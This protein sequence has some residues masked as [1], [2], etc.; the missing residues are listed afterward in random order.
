MEQGAAKKPTIG[1]V[2]GG[3]LGRMLTLAAKPL[4]FDVVVVDPGEHCPAEQ[5]GARQ[6]V[7]NLYD[8]KALRSCPLEQITSQSKSNIL[9]PMPWPRSNRAG[10]S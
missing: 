7:A 8:E 4:G 2:G 10:Q 6:I 9:T 5:V 1:I 3:Q